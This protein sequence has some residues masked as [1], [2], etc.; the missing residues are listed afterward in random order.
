MSFLVVQRTHEIGVRMALGAQRR[1][2]LS[3]VVGRAAKLVLFGTIIGLILALFSSRALSA[4]LYN[5]HAFDVPTFLLVT[6]VLALV[7]LL[8]SYIPAV[9]ATKADPM[10]ALG[11]GG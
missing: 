9:R 3:L 11:H 1:D 5:V 4:L 7:A 6:F 10:L 2:V 8:A